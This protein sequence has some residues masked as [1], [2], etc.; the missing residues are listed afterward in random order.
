[1]SFEG[2]A[3]AVVSEVFSKIWGAATD[4]RDEA[5]A[6]VQSAIAEARPTPRMQDVDVVGDYDLPTKP[7]I[8]GLEPG[9]MQALYDSVRLALEA[10]LDGKL[11]QFLEDFFPD[12]N[13]Y[14]RALDWLE[15]TLTDGGSGIN[16]EVERQ[17][18]ERDRARVMGET[19]RLEDEAAATWAARRFPLPPGALTGQINQIRLEAARQ[20][21]AQSRDVAIKAWEAELENTRLAVQQVLD[22][23][24]KAVAAAGDYIK[25]LMLGPQLASE[26]AMS[27]VDARIKIAQA[28]T[29]LYASEVQAQEPAVRM[30]LSRA[31]I[32]ARVGEANLRAEMSALEAR[33]QAAM[34]YAQMLGNMAAAGVNG[35]SA[36]A[37]ISGSDTTQRVVEG[38]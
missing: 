32:K 21:A 36:Q 5:E 11:Q 2:G 16:A 35:L 3:S 38:V 14:S 15:R 19:A 1:M 12:G 20:L 34:A 25:T 10:A 24:V 27:Q 37:S 26:L 17:L 7:Q 4:R 28:L 22:L 31:D 18:W 23:R 33:V 30:V 6:A 29:S 9:E 8:D 13:Y